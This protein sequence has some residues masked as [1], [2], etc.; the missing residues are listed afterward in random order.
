MFVGMV[1]IKCK[2]IREEGR[3]QRGGRGKEEEGGGKVIKDT[4]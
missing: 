2:S 1:I 4:W 3:R